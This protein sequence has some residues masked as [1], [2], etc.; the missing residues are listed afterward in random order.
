MQQLRI[1]SAAIFVFISF[2]VAG[3]TK[4]AQ[5]NSADW[6][7]MISANAAGKPAH[8]GY[9]LYFS[10][11][12]DINVPYLVYVPKSYDP[13]KPTSVVVFLHGAI[14]AR[15][16]FQYKDPAI[17]DEPIFSIADT[18]N[19]LVI[20]PF[21]KSGFAWP[22]QQAAC[23]NIITI[24]GQVEEHYNVDKK[25]VYIGGISMGGIATFWFIDNKPNVFAGFYT[26]SALPRSADFIHITK[27]KPL[28]SMNAKDDQTFSYN[29]VHTL[30]E[31]H[32]K[33][34]PGWDFQTVESGGHRFIYANG[35]TRYVKS[36]LGNLLK[37]AK[38]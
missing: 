26:F 24:I 3:Q 27:A 14:L 11:V 25:R 13:A 10:P 34:A 15:E 8:S 6:L 37:P 18:F 28:Y 36:L 23:E 16:S 2:A 19:T 32:K 30:Y 7:K 12:G 20:F 38:N 21:S 35:G 22:G 9:A 1:F 31:Q 29:E 4:E 33:E 5:M 17:A